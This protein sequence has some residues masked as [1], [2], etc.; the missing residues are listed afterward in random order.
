MFGFVYMST[1]ELEGYIKNQVMKEANITDEEIFN[2]YFKDFNYRDYL[3]YNYAMVDVEDVNELSKV[4]N[5]I[6]DKMENSK[7]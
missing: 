3:K 1:N 6:E 4:K 5:S 2:T 7:Q